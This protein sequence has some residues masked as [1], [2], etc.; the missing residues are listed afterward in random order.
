M[1]T[2]ADRAAKPRHWYEEFDVTLRFPRPRDSEI[3][4]LLTSLKEPEISLREGK[5]GM[6][7]VISLGSSSPSSR[8][9]LASHGKQL[10]RAFNDVL[11][12]KLPSK[13][14]TTW[15]EFSNTAKQ[16]YQLTW[17]H[18]FEILYLGQFHPEVDKW[19]KQINDQIVTVSQKGRRGRHPVPEAERRSLRRDYRGLLKK[20]AELHRVIEEVIV[21]ANNQNKGKSDLRRAIW[22]RLPSS[23]RGI[24]A[25]DLIFRGIAFQKIPYKRRCE[26]QLHDPKSWKA[27]QLAIALLAFRYKQEYQTIE[28][29]IRP[30]A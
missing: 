1:E 5:R 13:R 29:K 14:A 22:Q 11:W 15:V 18:L 9:L 3:R 25:R 19:L 8:S 12:Q 20:C 27:H 30:T 23:I 16:A 24:W 2:T 10:R 26:A 7:I 4:E 21:E 17:I 28:K 6:E